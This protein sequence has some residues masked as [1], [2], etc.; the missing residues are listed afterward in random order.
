[1]DDKFKPKQPPPIA[2]PEPP[3]DDLGGDAEVP[4]VKDRST[5]FKIVPIVG[6]DHS[7]PLWN[8]VVRHSPFLLKQV[9]AHASSRQEAKRLFLEACKE[10]HEKV[11]QRERGPE[12]DKATKRVMESYRQGVSEQSTYPWTIRP[13]AEVEKERK[14][15][16]GTLNLQMNLLNKLQEL[17]GQT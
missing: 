16:L 17:V 3:S 13:W 1:M 12:S 14:G 15:Y 5:G 10:H 11:S 4:K 6:T 2:A 9:N 8:V 7:K